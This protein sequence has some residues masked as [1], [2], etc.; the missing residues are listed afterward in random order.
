MLGT[1]PLS[2]GGII[3][4]I[5]RPTTYIAE[6]FKKIFCFT[7]VFCKIEPFINCDFIKYY[8]TDYLWSFSMMCCFTAV[9]P[10]TRMHYHGFAVVLM[11]VLWEIFQ[12]SHIISGTGD[13]KDIFMYIAAVFTVVLLEKISKGA[14]KNEKN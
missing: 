11:G 14:R 1:V 7:V 9:Q 6:F 5:C 4:I 10:N 8:F 3:Y 13:V 2:I 12:Y